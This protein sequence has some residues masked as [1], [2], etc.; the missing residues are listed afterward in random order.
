M[1]EPVSDMNE[2]IFE[3]RAYYARL[4]GIEYVSH[5]VV[6]L[7]ATSRGNEAVHL[8]RKN[9]QAAFVLLLFGGQRQHQ[10]GLD[11]SLQLSLGNNTDRFFRIDFLQAA[12]AAP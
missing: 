10:R 8:I 12:G 3:V 6:V 11:E 2:H 4:Q 9:E 1:S 7:A 5:G